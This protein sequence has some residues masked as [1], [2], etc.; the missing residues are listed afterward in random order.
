[1]IISA[2]LLFKG[3]K[4]MNLGLSTMNNYFI[5]GM[6]GAAVWMVT[7]IFAKT[8]RGESL[9]AVNLFDVQL[10]A[11]VHRLGVCVQPRQQ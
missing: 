11:G 2:M 1:M 7:F 8:L 10:D 9:Q 5:V 6:I 3:F 4:H